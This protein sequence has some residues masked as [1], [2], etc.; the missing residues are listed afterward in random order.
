MGYLSKL[1]FSALVSAGVGWGL[2]LVLGHAP[3]PS[4]R[5]FSMA[6][7]HYFGLTYLLN[8]KESKAVIRHSCVS[9]IRR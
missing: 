7:A 8:V 3:S 4:R 1:W 9:E 2:K 6:R 5:S